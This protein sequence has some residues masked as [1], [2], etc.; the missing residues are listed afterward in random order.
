M[1]AVVQTN[2]Q[3]VEGVGI[4]T[5]KWVCS[6]SNWLKLGKG[7]AEVFPLSRTVFMRISEFVQHDNYNL[8]NKSDWIFARCSQLPYFPDQ[9]RFPS[10]TKFLSLLL[11]WFSTHSHNPI[12]LIAVFRCRNG[13]ISSSKSPRVISSIVIWY[14]KELRSCLFVP[15]WVRLTRKEKD[16]RESNFEKSTPHSQLYNNYQT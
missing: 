10:D 8:F 16:L 2:K 6:N 5:P 11:L 7:R 14:H 9:K 1:T 3:S 13:Y 15:G 4:F 12:C